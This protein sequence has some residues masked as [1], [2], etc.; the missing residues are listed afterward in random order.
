M[1][2]ISKILAILI[3][4]NGA[5]VILLSWIGKRILFK[6]GKRDRIVDISTIFDMIDLLKA[7]FNEP[8]HKQYKKIALYNLLF[9][10]LEIILMLLFIFSFP[11]AR[12]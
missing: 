10:V 1:S 3:I 2:L 12:F 5:F 6:I 8:Q 4:F 7:S 11:I 9:F